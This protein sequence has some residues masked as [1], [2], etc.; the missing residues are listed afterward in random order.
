MAWDNLDPPTQ[1]EH[2][3]TVAN[4]FGVITTIQAPTPAV[5]ALSRALTRVGGRLV[6]A[7]DRKTPLSPW[8]ASAGFLSIER[9]KQLPHA[10]ATQLPENHY[11]RKNLAYLSAI[12]QGA[13][14]IFDTDDDN[15]PLA[16][17]VPRD[18]RTTAC[19][20]PARR[21]TNTYEL[22]ADPDERIWPRGFPLEELSASSELVR[23]VASR[24]TAPVQQSLVNGSPDVDAVWRLTQ[25]RPFTF[26][27]ERSVALARGSWCPFN[28]QSTWWFPK[29]YALL[30]LPS[31]VSFRMTD[32][33][34]SFVAQ[35]CLW[36]LGAGLVFHAPEMYQERNPHVLLRD[37][38]QEIPGY[39]GN[40]RLCAMLEELALESAA[41]ATGTNVRRCYEALARAGFVEA[42]ELPL[43]DA[44]L[45]DLGE[46]RRRVGVYAG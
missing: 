22:F 16:T 21:W 42:R 26:R 1:G 24:V 6:V 45:H 12:E 35:R 37:F 25:D 19:A 11:S 40:A 9:Q 4:I 29:A 33:W 46:L 18:E 39:L 36:E 44:W 15:A 13:S 34:R 3:E 38:E 2:L 32:I 28:S 14:S 8:E 41:E 10:L 31:Y 7:G 43:V 20:V 5:E 23:G 17:W 30:Y 27:N